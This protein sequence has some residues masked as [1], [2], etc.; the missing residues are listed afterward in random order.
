MEG[1]SPLLP[2]GVFRRVQEQSLSLARS[3]TKHG[4]S[5][6]L[7]EFLGI[8]LTLRVGPDTV[9]GAVACILAFMEPKGGRRTPCL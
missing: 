3:N 2:P 9:L 4:G 5:D 6:S 1:G 8:L 7:K